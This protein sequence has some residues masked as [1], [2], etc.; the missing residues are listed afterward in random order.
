MQ[1]ADPNSIIEEVRALL[2]TS[3]RTEDVPPAV[4]LMSQ[5]VSAV[6]LVPDMHVFNVE[7]ADGAVHVCKLFPKESCTC[8][9]S[10]TCCHIIAARES[11]GIETNKRS[12]INLSV[13][14]QNSR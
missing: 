1:L 14:K 9:S 8:P 4:K 7:G 2:H 3:D 5:A 13:L 11:I 10:T 6:Q 12:I